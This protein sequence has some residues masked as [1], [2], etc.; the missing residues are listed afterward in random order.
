MALPLALKSQWCN[1]IKLYSFL[2]YRLPCSVKAIVQRFRA[3]ISIYLVAWT[4]FRFSKSSYE[5]STFRQQVFLTSALLPFEAGSFFVCSLV[6]CNI[7]VSL[8]STHYIPVAFFQLWWPKYLQTLPRVPG[9][10]M[11]EAKISFQW[12]IPAWRITPKVLEARLQSACISF[13]KI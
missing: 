11:K 2:K 13:T 10:G 12:K 6:H 4:N 5:S 1:A 9:S 3:L 8:A 7:A